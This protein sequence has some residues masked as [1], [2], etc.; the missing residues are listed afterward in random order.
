MIW[1]CSGFLWCHF[2]VHVVDYGPN[3]IRTSRSFMVKIAFCLISGMFLTHDI[4]WTEF[5]FSLSLH[6]LCSFSWTACIIN[7]I[8]FLHLTNISISLNSLLNF[9][10]AHSEISAREEEIFLLSKVI[11]YVRQTLIFFQF[12]PWL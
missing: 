12:I 9:D 3:G 7:F 8:D 10:R 6:S 2:I 11:W 4:R 1:N 5:H